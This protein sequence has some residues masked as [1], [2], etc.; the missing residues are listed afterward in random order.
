MEAQ[1]RDVRRRSMRGAVHVALLLFVACAKPPAP[2]V[3]TAFDA[4]QLSFDGLQRVKSARFAGVWMRS[5][6]DFSVYRKLMLLP[7]ELA[8]KEAPVQ[9]RK[10]DAGFPLDAG[11]KQRL[12]EMAR[13]VFLSELVGRGGWQVVDAPGPDVL[14]VQGGLIDLVVRVPPSGAASA[15]AAPSLSSYGAMT[16]VMQFYDSQTRQILARVVDRRE[17]LPS[18]GSELAKADVSV[19]AE[20]RLFFQEWAKRLREGLDAVRAPTGVGAAKP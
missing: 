10:S 7:A 18:A 17:V 6:T 14:L 8:Y 3:A 16:L 4:E 11:Q 20:L 12:A 15:R 19:P 1:S 13:T 2:S 9:D 5:D